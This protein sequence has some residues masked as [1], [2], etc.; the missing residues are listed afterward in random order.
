MQHESPE[1]AKA[2]GG[3]EGGR[4]AG[5]VKGRQGGEGGRASRAAER[6]WMHCLPW[7]VF[8]AQG[9]LQAGTRAVEPPEPPQW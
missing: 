5:R 2:P 9:T 6:W 4:E 8:T 1:A 3:R 7:E